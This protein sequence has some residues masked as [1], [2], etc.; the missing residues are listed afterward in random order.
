MLDPNADSESESEEQEL[1]HS[2][3]HK[4]PSQ[5]DQEDEQNLKRQ[6]V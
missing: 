2:V 6:E 5:F 1:E 4:R 3:G